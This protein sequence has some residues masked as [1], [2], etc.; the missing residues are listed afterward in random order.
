MTTVYSVSHTEGTWYYATKEEAV[1]A[2]REERKAGGE[3]VE[4]QAQQICPA[5]ALGGLRQLYCALLNTQGYAVPG[6]M[7]SVEF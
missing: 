2:A 5:K 4:V 6:S 7:H 1:R 3:Y